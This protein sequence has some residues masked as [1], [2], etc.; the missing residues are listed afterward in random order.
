M[1]ASSSIERTRRPLP[2]P[3]ERGAADEL[4]RGDP[5]LGRLTEAIVLPDCRCLQDL[6]KFI[7]RIVGKLDEARESTRE[8]RVGADE[9]IH[10]GRVSRDD[11]DR[12][13]HGGPPSA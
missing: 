2:N 9:R 4:L 1:T 10:L 3:R 7:G 8:T 5:S 11:D 13:S 12:V 6:D